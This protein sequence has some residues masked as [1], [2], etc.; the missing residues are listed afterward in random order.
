MVNIRPEQPRK[1]LIRE[2]E[3]IQTERL[4]R[5]FK[6]GPVYQGFPRTLRMFLSL[7]SLCKTIFMYI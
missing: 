3:R 1:A 5:N 2:R 6:P 4:P 7:T